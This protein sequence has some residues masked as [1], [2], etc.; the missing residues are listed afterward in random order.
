MGGEIF[1]CAT[2]PTEEDALAGSARNWINYVKEQ[3]DGSGNREAK[4]PDG[5]ILTDLSGLSDEQIEHLKIV[6]TCEGRFVT[7]NGTTTAFVGPYQA[8]GVKLWW[9]PLPD[10]KYMVGVKNCTIKPYDPSWE[11]PGD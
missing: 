11:H 8:Y 6:G 2:Y 1:D 4:E 10:A 3:I 7:D 9:Y 5:K